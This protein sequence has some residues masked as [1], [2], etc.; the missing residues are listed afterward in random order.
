MTRFS[1]NRIVPDPMDQ[2]ES[3]TYL[4]RLQRSRPNGNWRIRLE[5]VGVNEHHAFAA[6][7]DLQ[8]FLQERME[9][10]IDDR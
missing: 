3:Y 5:T 1:P 7:E 10:K 8:R 9:G 4:L 6:L 2:P